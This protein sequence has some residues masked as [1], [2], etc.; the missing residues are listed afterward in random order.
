MAVQATTVV[1]ALALLLGLALAR[2]FPREAGRPT[3]S[4]DFWI[5]IGT[6]A[7]LFPV[8][9]GLVAVGLYNLNVGMVDLGAVTHPA[10]QFAFVF[11]L[12]DFTKYVVHYADHRVPLLWRFHRVHHSTEH[13]D[14]TAGLRMHVVD[15]LQLS[16]IPIMLFGVLFDVSAF[17]PWVLPVALSTGIVA[18]SLEHMNVRMS[19][20]DP[21]SRLWYYTFNSPL[22]HSWH[23]VRDG[24]LCDGNYANALPAWDYLFGTNVSRSTPPQVYGVARNPLQD[25]FIGLHLLRPRTQPA[26]PTL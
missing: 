6:G 3:F 18:D 5:N 11:L 9:L 7:C 20:D 12:L 15:F 22:F 19:L 1:Q 8:R 17:H 24:H 13:L 2:L 25:D 14:A 26:E 16:A 21:L 4:R 10:L 23:H